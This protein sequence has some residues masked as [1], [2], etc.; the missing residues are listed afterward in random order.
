MPFRSVLKLLIAA[1][2]SLGF[3]AGHAVPSGAQ[4]DPEFEAESRSSGRSGYTVRQGDTLESIARATGLSPAQIIALNPG[5]NARSL[6]APGIIIYLPIFG[7]GPASVAP[8]MSISP[9]SGPQDTIVQIRGEG[10]RANERLR[11]LAGTD[12]YGLRPIEIVR[13]GPRGRVN[14]TAGLPPARG[15]RFIYLAL[16]STDRRLQ[17]E[18]VRFRVEGRGPDNSLVRVTGRIADRN[19]ACPLLRGDD[20][21]T[22]SLAGRLDGFRPGDR[23]YVEGRR[24]EFSVC[25]RGTTIE[26]RRI[27]WAR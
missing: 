13:A 20:G 3:A 11:L 4:T 19:L 21:R 18:P 1:V 26:V 7:G 12:P 14:I 5:I 16:Q 10:F 15:A 24:V 9:R 25:T 23:V 2:L 17:L 27:G 8:A 6:L 22:Y